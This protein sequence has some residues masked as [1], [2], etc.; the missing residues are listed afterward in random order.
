MSN[1]SYHQKTE[2]YLLDEFYRKLVIEKV[3]FIK[4]K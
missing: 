1:L 3:N 4:T 2:K